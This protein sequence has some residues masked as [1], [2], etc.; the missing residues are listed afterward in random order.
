[1]TRTQTFLAILAAVAVT[2]GCSKAP[3]G[4]QASI[5]PGKSLESRVAKLEQDLKA[6]QA[7]ASELETKFRAEQA[8]GQAVEKERDELRAGL[9]TRTAERDALQAQFDGFR[10]GIKDLLGQAEAAQAL[11]AVPTVPSGQPATVHTSADPKGL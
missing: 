7:Q 11:P 8:R 4:Q 9:K 3:T 5:A 1:M 6:A 10:K 2:W